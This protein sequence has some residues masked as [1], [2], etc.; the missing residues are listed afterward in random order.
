VATGNRLRVALV[1]GPGGADHD[2]VSDY[3]DCLTR[4]LASVDVEAFPILVSPIGSRSPVRWL[5]ATIRAARAVRCLRPDLVHVQF[6]PSAYRFSAVPGLLP[7]LLPRAIPLVTTVHEYGCWTTVDWLPHRLRRALERT[8]LW[9]RE[10]GRLVPASAAVVT[11]NPRHAAVVRQRTG[12]DPA[13]VPLAPNVHDHRAGTGARDRVRRRLGLGPQARLV[14]FFGFVHPV[15][16]L[17]YVIEAL[18]ALR[19]TRPDLH[20]LV[21]G[22]F[23]SQALPEPEARAFRQELDDL[24]HAHGV[25]DAVTFTGH[26]PADAVSE[27]LHAADAAVLPFTTGVT[28]KSGALLT[29]LT[30][31]LPTAVTVPDEPDH[32][33]RD[34]D[35]VAVIPARRDAAAVAGT[36]DRLLDDPALRRRLADGGRRL[37]ARHS[38]PRVAAAHRGL[39]ERV[40]G[41]RDA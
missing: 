23:T 1:R 22:G 32:R 41:F 28:T 9:D 4:A 14:A 35:N 11:T 15:K 36:L 29:A 33:L 6:A 24:A 31:G 40:L 3:V 5:P 13:E 34:G 20:L 37:A 25:A 39:Y 17:R 2:G 30:H 18:P 7:L 26:L 19:A 16:G 12:K 8:G 10:S 27:A 38:W 21:L